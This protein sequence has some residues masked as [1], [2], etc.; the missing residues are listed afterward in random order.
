MQSKKR[1]STRKINFIEEDINEI[2]YLSKYHEHPR[3]RQKMQG[4]WLRSQNFSQKDIAK[5]LSVSENTV[6][7]YINDYI[8]GG[9]EKLK[10]TNFYQPK[11]ELEKYRSIIEKD[12]S[13][14]S[15]STLKEANERI[16]KLTGF[17]RSLPQ[18]SQ[19]LKSSGLR[20]LK[21]GHIPAKANPEKQQDFLKYRA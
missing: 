3:I 20:R 16:K 11:S 18:I 13:E 14:N 12:F 4:V 2:L 15:V 21:V 7:S 19:F 9:I 6:R 10:E 17:Q 8:D 5:I 1:R